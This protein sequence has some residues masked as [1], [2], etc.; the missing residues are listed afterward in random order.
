MKQSKRLYPR[1]TLTLALMLSCAA[2]TVQAE[3]FDEKSAGY[4][5]NALEQLQKLY[6][7]DEHAVIA[8]LAAEG[9]AADLYRRIKDLKLEGYAGAWFD[10][11][12]LRLHVALASD[13]AAKRVS[14]LGA[15]PVEAI[16]SLEELEEV[17]ARIT[18]ARISPQVV[19]VWRTVFIDPK[20]NKV[21]VGAFPGQANAA[22]SLLLE[23]TGQIEVREDNV[24]V[25]PRADVRGADGTWNYSWYLENNGGIWKCS[26][27]AAVE[28]GYYTAGHCGGAARSYNGADVIKFAVNYIPDTH[29]T[30][31][32]DPT[33]GTVVD[34]GLPFYVG[35]MNKDTAWVDT[36][37]GWTATPKINGGTDGVFNVPAK[38]S[39]V[40]SP[41]IG[42]HVC[43]YGG[44][45][46]GPHCGN[47]STIGVI[48]NWSSAYIE[49]LIEV[50]G[51]CASDGDSG[52]P[53]V[54]S[55]G[56]QLLGTLFGGQSGIFCPDASITRYQPITDH[57]AEYEWAAG[58]LLT[59]HGAS[60]PT[61]SGWLCPDTSY[62][63]SGVFACSFDYYNSQ[64]STSYTWYLNNGAQSEQSSQFSGTCIPDKLVR[65][66]LTVTNP[67]GSVTQ[68]T[69]FGCPQ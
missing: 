7:I 9:E 61:V 63:G 28:N 35:N 11:D 8:R 27:G 17:Q 25:Q 30:L 45:S 36:V 53:L 20:I 39:G 31:P 32:P 62:G 15:I 6:G 64:G 52:G 65:V 58:S 56:K 21:V 49:N 23:Y 67:Y 19:G 46:G 14:K 37:T 2:L 18:D 59:A 5:K 26:I 4:G 60:A 38:W 16:W 34:S 42:T 57:I 10:G 51:S 13:K 24:D 66:K 54:T 29:P 47:I 3:A 69:T 41:L 48:Y 55:A 43:R 40:G 44:T 50:T 12:S 33:L 68:Q 22:Q 1:H